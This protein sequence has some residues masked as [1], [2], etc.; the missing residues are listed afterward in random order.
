MLQS[1]T[2]VSTVGRGNR[3]SCN[4]ENPLRR[5]MGLRKARDKIEDD[6]VRA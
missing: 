4:V 1:G 5:S 2:P 3:I 6:D